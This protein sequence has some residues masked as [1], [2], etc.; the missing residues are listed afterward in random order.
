MG[1]V[2]QLKGWLR[3]LGVGTAGCL[4]KDDLRERLRGFVSR[5]APVSAETSAP[6]ATA[7]TMPEV[8]GVGANEPDPPRLSEG[9]EWSFCAPPGRRRATP[10]AA[11]ATAQSSEP[12]AARAEPMVRGT[13]RAPE[14]LASE[15]DGT[16]PARNRDR[17]MPTRP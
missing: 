4:T 13:L 2:S 10:S 14:V 17:S 8:N 7:S 11:C 1:G 5:W 9:P 3:D 12:D 16:S 15:F 6:P